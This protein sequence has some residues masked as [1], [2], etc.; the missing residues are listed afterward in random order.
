[1]IVGR[2]ALLLAGVGLALVAR[3][4]WLTGY[5]QYPPEW[6][7]HATMI[8]GALLLSWLFTAIS[9]NAGARRPTRVVASACVP[10]VLL[11][12]SRALGGVGSA[13]TLIAVLVLVVTLALPQWQRREQGRR[14]T[15]RSTTRQDGA[16]SEGTDASETRRLTNR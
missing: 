8:I 15:T 16:A 12:Y 13:I 9:I 7:N 2:T 3:S 10:L 4:A 11:P 6:R 14:A 5:S 1:M